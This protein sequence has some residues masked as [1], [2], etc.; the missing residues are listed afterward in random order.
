MSETKENILLIGFGDIAQRLSKKLFN[1]YDITGIRRSKFHYPGV[2]VVQA[3]ILD[4]SAMASLLQTKRDVIVITLTPDDMSDEGYQSAY[5]KPLEVLLTSLAGQD[6]RPRL[7]LFIS[8]TSVYGQ[9]NAE[10]V[11]EISIT[12]PKSYSGQRLLEAEKLLL[13]SHFSSCV[14]RFSG[15]YGPGRQRLI[16]QVIEGQGAEKEPI[17]YSN[18]IHADDCAGVLQHLIEKQKYE[19]IETHYLASDCEPTPLYEVKQWL[20]QQLNLPKEHLK[21]KALG[22]TLRSSKRCRNQRLLY[23]GYQFLYP[24]YQAGYR[25]VLEDYKREKN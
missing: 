24:N 18:R 2:S 20:A 11:D 14:V 5:V 3:N 19:T 15:I 17:L 4:T 8:S 25:K 1:Q 21:P 23:S 12:E 7:I 13:N 16:E 10:W 6:Y 22:R 9:Q